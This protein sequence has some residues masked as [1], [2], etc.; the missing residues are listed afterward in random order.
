MICPNCFANNKNNAAV[1]KS[2]GASLTDTENDISASSSDRRPPSK[3]RATY[4]A[5]E[6]FRRNPLPCPS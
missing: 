3:K 4:S 2:C 5:E 1:C 6:A